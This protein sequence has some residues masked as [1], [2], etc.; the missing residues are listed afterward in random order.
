MRPEAAH[1][2]FGFVVNS[3][4]GRSATAPKKFWCVGGHNG[5][6]V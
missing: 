6:D 5:I 3:E 1:S 2:R 4:L